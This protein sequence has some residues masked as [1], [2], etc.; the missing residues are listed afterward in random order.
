MSIKLSSLLKL[1]AASAVLISVGACKASDK[2]QGALESQSITALNLSKTEASVFSKYFITPPCEVDE[3]ES[4]G[5]LAGLGMGE[6]GAQGVSFDSREVN[7]GIVTYRNLTLKEEGSDQTAFSVKS[8]VFHCPQMGD[9]DP[10]FSRLDLSDVYI[11]DEGDD[12]EFTADTLNIANPT[13]EAA[14]SVVEG[15]IRPNSNLN[16]NVGFGAISITGATFKSPELN[17]SLEALSWGETRNEEGSGHA[18]LT[19]EAANFVVTGQNGAEDMTIDFDGMSA[20]NL[21]LSQATNS[22]IGLPSNEMIANVLGNLNKFEKPYDELIVETLK[23]NSEGFSVNFGGIEGQTSE[24]GKVITTRQSL[25]PTVINLKPALGEMPN[26]QQNYEILKSLNMETIKLS[27]SSVSTLNSGDDSIALSDGLL[28][29]DDVFRL[30]FEY[31]AEGLNEMGTKLRALQDRQG[32]SSSLAAYDALKLRGFRLTL[33]DN[34]I[35]DKGLKLATQMTG[36]SEANIKRMLSGAVFAVA[37]AAENEVQA[38]VYSESVEAFADFV[39]NGGTL[40]LEANP[41]AP[42]PLA[43]LIT[44]QGENIDPDSLGFSASQD[45]SN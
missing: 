2:G 15:M 43:P 6:S 22:Q 34:S 44:G 27:G 28:I 23:I 33:E 19:V 42:F 13:P 17:G 14:R 37:L 4:L 16:G 35:V 25:K 40:T 7:A 24:K 26:F 39:K 5:A 11:K 32:S 38:E 41:P 45:H 36:Q 29:V 10:N 30:N 18:D 12:V 31:E 21:H 9:E 1:S 8:A 3:L 20:R